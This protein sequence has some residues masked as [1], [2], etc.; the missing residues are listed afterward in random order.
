MRWRAGGFE[1]EDLAPIVVETAANVVGDLVSSE[2]PKRRRL[3]CYISTVVILVIIGI[4]SYV[5]F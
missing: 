3:G 2:N 1:V 4:V 5:F